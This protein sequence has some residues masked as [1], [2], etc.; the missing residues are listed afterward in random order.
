[1][2][3]DFAGMIINTNFIVS[4]YKINY[5]RNGKTFYDIIIQLSTSSSVVKEMYNT[6][7]EQE[8][9]FNEIIDTVNNE[10]K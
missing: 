8:T 3:I 1:M 7:E 4:I 5:T 10:K 9:R 2:F 6:K